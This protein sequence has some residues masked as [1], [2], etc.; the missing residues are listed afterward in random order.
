MS[1]KIKINWDNENVVSESVRI[2]RADTLITTPAQEMLIATIFGNVYEYEDL[3]TAEGQTYYYMLS[4]KLGEQEVFTECYEVSTLLSM[5][6]TF[7]L[8]SQLTDNVGQSL[9]SLTLPAHERGD[10]LIVCIETWG[11]PTSAPQVPEGFIALKVFGS[12]YRAVTV[13]YK[14]ATENSSTAT[15]TKN[16]LSMSAMVYGGA[17][18]ITKIDAIFIDKSLVTNRE[19]PILT[20]PN[21][22]VF[23]F[24]ASWSMRNTSQQQS[25][26]ISN[27]NTVVMPKSVGN[28]CHVVAYSNALK[29]SQSGSHL[30]SISGGIDSTAIIG[31]LTMHISA[32]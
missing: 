11:G 13:S 20:A 2:Y 24:F 7:I 26:A 28:L 9:R 4:A 5:P 10:L 1:V 19:F 22:G 29:N 23:L 16:S 3:T 12:E 25:A 27:S 17:K 30:L 14:I 6:I 15:V 31:M 18:D 32:K 21:D 8:S